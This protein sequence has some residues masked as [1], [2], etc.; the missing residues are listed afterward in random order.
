V[1]TTAA[2]SSVCTG[3][4]MARWPVALPLPLPLPLPDHTSM[5]DFAT[6]TRV[7]SLSPSV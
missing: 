5:P 3:T 6:S 2:T 1:P 4:E 7:D